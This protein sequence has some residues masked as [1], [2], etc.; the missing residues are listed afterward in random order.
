MMKSFAVFRPAKNFCPKG[1]FANSQWCERFVLQ[2]NNNNND[3]WK[4]H[5]FLFFLFF[6]PPLLSLFSLSF[7]LH[8]QAVEDD[9]D[10]LHIS[11][12]SNKGEAAEGTNNRD[13]T[14]LLKLTVVGKTN[15]KFPK[16]IILIA[17]P[18]SSTPFTKK[19]SSL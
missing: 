13:N 18:N 7:S 14:S 10:K 2:I 1:T 12:D 17:N 6:F 9:R 4:I 11:T 16:K 3:D 19:M 5:N 15:T 8:L